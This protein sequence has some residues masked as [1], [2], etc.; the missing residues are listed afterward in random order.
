M[1]SSQSFEFGKGSWILLT[2]HRVST[3]RSATRMRLFHR[4]FGTMLGVILG[5]ALATCC[6]AGPY[7][8]C[9]APSTSS[10]LDQPELHHRGHF[11]PP[12]C[13]RVQPALEPGHCGDAARIIETVIG[14]VL[15][16]CWC[17]RVA[18]MAIQTAATL[19]LKAI[20][21]ASATSEHLRRNGYR[22]RLPAQPSLAY[23]AD[24]E[25]TS[26]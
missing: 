4:V 11:V 25:L 22:G 3:N 26:A 19:L 10:M 5:V 17:D 24:N 16:S 21:R 1:P 6:L 18:R 12:T 9:W 13:W 2:S 8:C 7:C 23:N 15:A 20:T 14:E